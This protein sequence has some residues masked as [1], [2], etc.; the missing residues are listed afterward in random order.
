ME[1]WGYVYSIGDSLKRNTPDLTAVKGWCSS[2]YGFGLAA[3]TKID[4]VRI[5]ATQML[6]QHMSDEETKSK[7]A[8][9][10]SRFGKKRCCLW[11]PGGSQDHPRSV[12]RISHTLH[13]FWINWALNCF[14]FFFSTI[15]LGNGKLN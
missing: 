12:T 4:N 11:L 14:F 8:P 5:N 10:R 9:G 2:S 1:V 15:S 6:I 13:L 3:V 7:D